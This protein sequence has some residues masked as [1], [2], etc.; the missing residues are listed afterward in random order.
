METRS[1]A[2]PPRGAVATAM[3][4]ERE[5]PLSQYRV[6]P[7][8]KTCTVIHPPLRWVGSARWSS[9]SSRS[10]T[11]SCSAP[12]SWTTGRVHVR[13]LC[14]RLSQ[15]NFNCSLNHARHLVIV[16]TA[17]GAHCLTPTPSSLL[18]FPCSAPRSWTT[19]RGH[20]RFLRRR[21]SQRN[22]NCSLNHALYLVLVST[23]CGANCSTPLPSSLFTTI[24]STLNTTSASQPRTQS[25]HHSRRLPPLLSML[26]TRAPSL[27]GAGPLGAVTI[28]WSGSHGTGLVRVLPSSLLAC[29]PRVGLYCPSTV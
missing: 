20:V 25:C 29:G 9:S 15:R 17:C 10:H 2:L 14:R 7:Q 3:V 18:T 24:T 21:L 22:F 11:L 8:A 28:Y 4:P 27:A 5:G 16:S 6:N 13:F 19:G 12:R 26:I 23:A 1:R